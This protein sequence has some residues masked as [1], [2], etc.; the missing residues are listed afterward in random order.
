M[1]RFKI[2]KEKVMQKS[3]VETLNKPNIMAKTLLWPFVA[4]GLSLANPNYAQGTSKT[5]TPEV[6]QLEWEGWSI[7]IDQLNFKSSIERYGEKK[8]GSDSIFVHLAM[9]VKNNKNRGEAFIPQNALKIVIGGNEYDAQ[10]LDVGAISYMDNI[11]PTLVRDRLCYF[12]LPTNQ[13]RNSLI[14]RFKQFLTEEK[15]VKV[16]IGDAPEPAPTPMPKP[17]AEVDARPQ[18]EPVQQWVV[19]TPPPAPFR[20]SRESADA[21]LTNAWKALTSQQRDRLGQEER[22]WTRRRDSLPAEERIKSTADRAK[23]I[24]SLVERTLDD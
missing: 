24:W 6:T 2:Q 12:E 17:E 3:G 23:Y 19:S 13:L 20:L 5:L 1:L 7:K 21:D 11:E 22:N 4:I 15:T 16:A 18:R 9:T 10:D 14:L 8:A